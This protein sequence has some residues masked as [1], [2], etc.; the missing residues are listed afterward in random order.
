MTTQPPNSL[1]Q[2]SVVTMTLNVP[3]FTTVT[4]SPVPIWSPEELNHAISVATTPSAKET[5]SVPWVPSRL[6]ALTTSTP[7]IYGQLTRKLKSSNVKGTLNGVKIVAQAM[8]SMDML[9]KPARSG[10]P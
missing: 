8:M 1:W 10:V 5:V 3:G 2:S 9:Y 4:D 7:S 6:L